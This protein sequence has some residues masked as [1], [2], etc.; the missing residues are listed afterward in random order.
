VYNEIGHILPFRNPAMNFLMDPNVAY[1]LLVG[2]LLLAVLVMFS[3]GTGVLEI[4]ALAMLV[5]AGF[6]IANFTINFWALIVL[7]LGIFPFILAVRRSRQ[8]I[9]LAIALA[10][11][12]VGTVFLISPSETSPGINPVLAILVS[13]L[14]VGFLWFVA[15]RSLDALTLPVKSIARLVG[16]KGEAHTDIFAEGSAYVDGEEWSARSQVFIPA[17]REV[18][19]TGREGLTLL[20]EPLKP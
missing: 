1:I 5:L 7:V 13:A 11:L 15:R 2:G 3:P 19:V 9:F 4:G 10:A 14:V 20:V 6:S 12:V 8:Y 18:R 17:G 16:A